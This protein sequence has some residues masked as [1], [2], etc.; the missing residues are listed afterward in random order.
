[1]THLI[2]KEH[3]GDESPLFYIPTLASQQ[4][5]WQNEIDYRIFTKTTEQ[6][7]ELIKNMVGFHVHT[8]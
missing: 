1:M 5:L 8:N 6:L 4:K 7:F 2:I 3:L